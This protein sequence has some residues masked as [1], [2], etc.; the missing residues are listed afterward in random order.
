MKESIAIM[1]NA[2]VNI[3]INNNPSIYLFGSVV[4]DDFQSGWSDI[5]ILC[6]TECSISNDQA[7]KLL[8]LRQELSAKHIDNPYFR[9]F[10]GGFISLEAFLNKQ[11]D[12][13]VY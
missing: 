12:K 1:I 5:D 11:E 3:L 4:L 2:I 6:L 7:E 10:E 8:H 13:V 9:A